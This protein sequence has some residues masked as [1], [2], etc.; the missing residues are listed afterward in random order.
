MR[1][2]SDISNVGNQA[3]QTTRPVSAKARKLLNDSRGN[4]VFIGRTK[5]LGETLNTF[6]RSLMLLILFVMVLKDWPAQ[7][8]M[9]VVLFLI[10]WL[11]LIR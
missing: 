11:G 3:R 10:R 1:N 7:S 9:I 5:V 8:I 4:G 6:N 2:A